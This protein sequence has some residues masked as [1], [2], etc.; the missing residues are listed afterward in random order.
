MPRRR[1]Q[2]ELE[3]GLS[4][5][6]QA[7]RVVVSWMARAARLGLPVVARG[8]QGLVGKGAEQGVGQGQQPRS[9]AAVDAPSRGRGP[10]VTATARRTRRRKAVVVSEGWTAAMQRPR[11]VTVVALVAALGQ[12]QGAQQAQERQEHPQRLQRQAVGGKA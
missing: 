3:Q 7:L 8:V 12:A 4:R 1:L 10:T 2:Q 9:V 6:Q 5:R 11:G